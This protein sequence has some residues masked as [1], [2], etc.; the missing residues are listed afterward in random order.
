L[1]GEELTDSELESISLR[2]KFQKAAI[3]HEIGHG[4]IAHMP[5]PPQPPLAADA[6]IALL[7][8]AKR[9]DA[10]LQCFEE[11]FE[12]DCLTKGLPRARV[13]HWCRVLHSVRPLLWPA[14]K[15]LF[16]ACVGL[17]VLRRWIG[18]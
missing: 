7:V 11:Y 14:L 15:R 8:P 16:A 4:S 1:K 9:A 17:D 18:R 2:V 13:L 6:L 10:I 12:R 5:R 3:V